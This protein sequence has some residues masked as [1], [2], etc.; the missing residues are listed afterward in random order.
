[1]T[2]IM[3]PVIA[4]KII[5]ILL[6]WRNSQLGGG[7]MVWLLGPRILLGDLLYLKQHKVD[8]AGTPQGPQGRRCLPVVPCCRGR[9]EQ[10]GLW[11]LLCCRKEAKE[12]SWEV[13]RCGSEIQGLNPSIFI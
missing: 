8:T 11:Q 6:A 1:M 5:M 4:V 10:C 2:T 12:K 9:D 3:T 7:A 13:I